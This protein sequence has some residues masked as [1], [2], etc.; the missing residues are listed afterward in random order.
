MAQFTLIVPTDEVLDLY[1]TTCG[2]LWHSFLVEGWW[3]E[4]NGWFGLWALVPESHASTKLRPK[5]ASERGIF[6]KL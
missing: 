4:E 5:P 3:Q 2:Y 1:G 6:S